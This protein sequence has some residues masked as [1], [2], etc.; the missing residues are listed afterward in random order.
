MC[1]VIILRRPG[2]D[3][4][5]LMAANRDEMRDRAWEPPALHWP[6]RPDV[7]GG[8]DTLAGGTWMALNGYGLTAALLNRMN[9]LGPEDGKRSRG[10]LVLEALDHADASA[11]AQALADLNTDAYRSFN[12]VVADNHDAFWLR[13]LGSG[14]VDVMPIPEGVSMIT[15][16]DLDD[17]SD[18]RVAA[19]LPRFRTQSPPNPDVAE[20]WS[21]WQA[22]LREGE[23]NER[24]ALWVD[25]DWGFGTVCSSVL[26]LPAAG[27]E[28][29][30]VWLFAKERTGAFYSVL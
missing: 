25:T 8:M 11:A 20:S 2:H 6:D 18:P 14:K 15:A 16:Y 28:K 10:E 19:F 29:K 24:A 22:L 27:L 23:A 9:S 5:V 12:M 21:G 3:W 26:A 13:S 1:S 17:L 4:P 30:P 7:I